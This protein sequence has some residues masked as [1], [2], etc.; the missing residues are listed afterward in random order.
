MIYA[1]SKHAI[2]YPLEIPADFDGNPLLLVTPQ[3]VLAAKVCECGPHCLVS[4]S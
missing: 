1:V 2:A 4:L 3:I